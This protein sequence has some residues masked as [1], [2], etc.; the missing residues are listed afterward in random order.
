MHSFAARKKGCSRYIKAAEQRFYCSLLLELSQPARG[1]HPIV[2]DIISAL[3]VQ[4]SE[5]FVDIFSRHD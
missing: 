3:T 4:N 5:E 2:T 1:L